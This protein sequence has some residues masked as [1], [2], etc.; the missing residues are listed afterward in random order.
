MI[1]GTQ[2]K[3]SWNSVDAFAVELGQTLEDVL[4]QRDGFRHVRYE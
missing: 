3:V 2:E 4:G 1:E